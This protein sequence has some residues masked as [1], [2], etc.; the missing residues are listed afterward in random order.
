MLKKLRVGVIG[1]GHGLRTLRPGFEYA[2]R[3]QVVGISGSSSERA[4][5]YA[6]DNDIP[7]AFESAEELCSS[8]EID[9]ICV[10]SPNEFHLDHA[11]LAL[12]SKK[13]VYLEKPVACSH[14]DAIQL[15]R[16]A[17]VSSN[18][19]VVVGHQLR[20]NP[21]IQYMR[22]L[23]NSEQLGEIYSI[24]ITQRGG[25]FAQLNRPW[26]WE[27]DRSVGGG[28]R[29]AMG[30]HLLDASN[31]LLGF[32]PEAIFSGG[33]PVH[34]KR[35]RGD[36]ATVVVSIS[37]FF[38]ATAD[39]GTAMCHISTSAASHGPG[40][41]KIEILGS[42]GVAI[43]NG[44]S[45]MEFFRDGEI[46]IDACPVD[47]GSYE[48][49]PGSSVFR[50]SLTYFADQ[51]V[52]AI[53]A[54]QTKLADAHTLSDAISLLEMLDEADREFSQRGPANRSAF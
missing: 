10:A 36:G 32:A 39:Y 18:R 25:A 48:S 46:V 44:G 34:R 51:I 53:E 41:F 17:D 5:L 7:I 2:G 49:R 35:F 20:F 24:N 47:S 14:E 1:T 12:S 8:D 42:K 19:L 22:D 33:H 28:V 16:F 23:V 15:N 43:Y 6:A 45:S 40:E 9:L 4:R 30:T 3:A 27:F 52:E 54:G 13:H 37:N 31:F 38:S 50:K 11:M 26:T 29:L 21:F